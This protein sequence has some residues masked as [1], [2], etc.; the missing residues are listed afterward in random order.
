MNKNVC[1]LQLGNPPPVWV[2]ASLSSRIY[3]F[4]FQADK[5][6]CTWRIK[7]F[8]NQGQDETKKRSGEERRMSSF[9]LRWHLIPSR[10][11]VRRAAPVCVR[12][13]EK[14]TG[15]PWLAGCKNETWG[16]RGWGGTR[17]AGMGS[18][19]ELYLQSSLCWNMRICSVAFHT[20][21]PEAS[22]NSLTFT[23]WKKRTL[24]RCSRRCRLSPAKSL[25][26]PFFCWGD[27]GQIGGCLNV[28]PRTTSKEA[29]VCTRRHDQ[30]RNQR[31]LTK[32]NSLSKEGIQ[33]H[34]S[35]SVSFNKLTW[36]EA[37]DRMHADEQNVCHHYKCCKFLRGLEINWLYR[38]APDG[39]RKFPQLLCIL[40]SL[41]T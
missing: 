27:R 16:M 12:S 10:V 38:L 41:R 37:T 28:V 29:A 3:R 30:S 24:H 2:I 25:M 33:C 15:W 8:Y 9:S 40:I 7:A 18:V 32:K 4:N 19:A 11:K 13:R 22:T 39:R 36:V 5:T 21:R 34:W 31:W 26:F 14:G 20:K 23:G 17:S 6:K 35:Y 1:I